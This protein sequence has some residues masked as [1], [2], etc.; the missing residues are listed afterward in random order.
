MLY[1]INNVINNQL[2][3]RAYE[4]DR[5]N[6]NFR[7]TSSQPLQAFSNITKFIQKPDRNEEK[8]TL[9]LDHLCI[10]QVRNSTALLFKKSLNCKLLSF[11]QIKNSKLNPIH[12]NNQE[13]PSQNPFQDTKSHQ[14]N[15]THS[16]NSS[17]VQSL[18]Q[19]TK[20]LMHLKYLST[21]A[22]TTGS[23][24]TLRSSAFSN[25]STSKLSRNQEHRSS[26]SN[27][28]SGRSCAS[29]TTCSKAD[30][31]L[32]DLNQPSAKDCSN[33]FFSRKSFNRE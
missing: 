15:F 22:R 20:Q 1:K 32:N 26:S 5:G 18:T 13:T 29:S 10:P 11:N 21:V 31:S 19:Q 28:C 2:R 23:W 7:S 8:I 9:N 17:L 16:N 14:L 33:N 24:S 27:S 3:Q 30:S 6:L 4:P 12:S 25:P